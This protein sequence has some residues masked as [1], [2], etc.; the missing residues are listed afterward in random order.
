MGYLKKR[1]PFFA[2]IKIKIVQFRL[3]MLCLHLPV[4]FLI[5]LTSWLLYI[6]SYNEDVQL[7]RVD[8]LKFSK[9]SSFTDVRYF[10]LDICCLARYDTVALLAGSSSS[11]YTCCLY[12]HYAPWQPY[13][14]YKSVC[15]YSAIKCRQSLRGT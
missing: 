10:K 12:F 9:R 2:E 1:R 6:C 4:V 3:I 11:A 15:F 13:S 14:L 5:S 8:R 7:V